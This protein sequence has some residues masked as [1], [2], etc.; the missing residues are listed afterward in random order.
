MN[1]ARALLC[2]ALALCLTAIAPTPARVRA[3]ESREVQHRYS[4][5]HVALPDGIDGSIRV[6]LSLT[7]STAFARVDYY[8][9][10]GRYLGTYEETN[11]FCS[12]ESDCVLE[13]ALAHYYD[14]A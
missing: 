9:S 11:G 12:T 1:G 8:T 6:G 2:G 14:R 5:H 13:F 10:G 7:P 3:S 4:F